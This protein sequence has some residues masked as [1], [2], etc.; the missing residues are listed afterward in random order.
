MTQTIFIRHQRVIHL[1]WWGYLANS[2]YGYQWWTNII[3]N[4][5]VFYASGKGGQRIMIFRDLNMVI[6]TT[7]DAVSWETNVSQNQ[8]VME[9]ID[10]ILDS[11]E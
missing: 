3:D 5:N 9:L 10:H 1:P 11:A 7:T 2:G 6:V 4:Y 8:S